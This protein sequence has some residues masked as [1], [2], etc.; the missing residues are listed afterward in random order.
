MIELDGT[1]AY[2]QVGWAAWQRY[3]C[4]GGKMGSFGMGARG[5]LRSGFRYVSTR[6]LGCGG[7]WG[8]E[9]GKLGLEEDIAMIESFGREGVRE[10]WC[11]ELGE[12]FCVQRGHHWALMFVNNCLPGLQVTVARIID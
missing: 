8:C 12:E 3:S 5:G 7:L 9:V 4:C 11:G 1:Q 10:V 2:R 6:L